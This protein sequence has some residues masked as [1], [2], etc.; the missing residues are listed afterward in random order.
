MLRIKRETTKHSRLLQAQATTVNALPGEIV[1]CKDTACRHDFYQWIGYA[2]TFNAPA[3]TL[4]LSL[5]ANS[6]FKVSLQ[7][8]GL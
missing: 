1:I 7:K 5:G 2:N 8:N 4:Q 6:G 3:T